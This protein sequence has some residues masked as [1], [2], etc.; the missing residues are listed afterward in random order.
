MVGYVLIAIAIGLGT[1]ILVYDAYGYGINTKTGDIV[2]NGLLFVDSK[3]G[4]ANIYLNGK[5]QNA[6]T[7]ARLILPAATYT[8]KLQKDGYRDW[9]RTLTL[10][11]HS[12]DRF[13]YPFLFPTK[14]TP[15]DLKNYTSS[16]ALFT[17]SPDRRWLL[18]QTAPTSTDSLNFDMFD[19]GDIKLPA[20]SLVLPNSLLNTP[21]QASDTLEEVEWSNDNNHLLLRHNFNGGSE[22][23]LF[24]RQTPGESV[25]LNKLFKVNPS[26][27]ILRDKKADRVYVFNKPSGELRIGDVGDGTLEQPIISKVL[28]FK[29]SGPDLITYVTDS[30]TAG[31]V[32]GRI[33]ENGKSYT[34]NQFSVADKYLMDAA[35]FQGHWYYVAGGSS[36]DQLNI[37]KDPL[38]GLKNPSIKK[39]SPMIGLRIKNATKLSFSANTRFIGVENGQQFAVYD[40]EAKNYYNY[41]TSAPLDGPAHWMDGHRWLVVSNGKVLAMDYD[42]TNQQSLVST[43]LEDAGYFD[44]DYNRLFTAVKSASGFTVQVTEMRAGSDLPKQ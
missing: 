16:Q 19:T 40:I 8:L 25:N 7:A 17:Q 11:E 27:V 5:Y 15:K 28:A 29:P 18:V 6:D 9:Q 24:D 22:F 34:L 35:Q 26:E 4:G 38:D 3:P 21:W 37:Y 33:W 44:R 39:A 20:K 10:T 32:N 2:Q 23:I 1:V 43:T 31:M 36:S 41:I 30:P 14:P 42:N 12:I 13:V